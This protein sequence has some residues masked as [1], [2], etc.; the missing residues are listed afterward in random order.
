MKFLTRYDRNRSFILFS[1][2]SRVKQSFKDECDINKIL[3]R[4]Q[5]TGVLD[6]VNRYQGDYAD[7][8]PIPDYREA[9]NSVMAAQAAFNSLPS[10]IRERFGNDPAQFLDFVHDEGNLNEMRSLGLLK[11]VEPDISAPPSPP[12][13]EGP[14]AP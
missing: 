10:K 12:V 14:K 4:W 5:K 11:P 9:L 2:P 13:A 7:V 1:K 3:A 8:T 6:H